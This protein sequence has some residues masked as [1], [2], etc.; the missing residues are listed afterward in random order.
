M[1]LNSDANSVLKRKQKDANDKILTDLEITRAF[2]QF[3]KESGE[4]LKEDKWIKG[5][6][7]KQLQSSR[8]ELTQDTV[9]ADLP[10]EER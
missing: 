3:C 9:L 7:V 4:L 8:I 10:E 2:G 1:S 6:C 5:A